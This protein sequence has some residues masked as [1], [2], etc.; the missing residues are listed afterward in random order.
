MKGRTKAIIR[1]SFLNAICIPHVVDRKTIA[2]AN[3][4]TD[5]LTDRSRKKTVTS[6][7]KV[8][9]TL[10]LQMEDWRFIM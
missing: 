3:I 9:T 6:F 1:V 5:K 2:L 8:E 7:M 4:R 10:P